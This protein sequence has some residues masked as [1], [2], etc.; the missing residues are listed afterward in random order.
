[1]QTAKSHIPKGNIQSGFDSVKQ[2]LINYNQQYTFDIPLIMSPETAAELRQLGLI[3]YKAINFMVNNYK[4]CLHIIPRTERELEILNI[5]EKFPY[6]IGTFRTDFIIDSINNIKI[7]EINAG[8]PFNGIFNSGIFREIAL[9]QA[10]RLNIAGIIDHY[11]GV[12]EYI[13]DYIGGAQQ[14]TV[15]YGEEAAGDRAV[16]SKLFAASGVP[17]NLIPIVE[18]PS[19]TNTMDDAFIIIELLGHEI[20]T[21][22]NEMIELLAAKGTH[23][24]ILTLLNSG[25]KKFFRALNHPEFLA[26][27]LTADEI[28][29][30]TKYVTPTYIYGADDTV[31][32]EAYENKNRF[33]LK[34]HFLGRSVEVYGGRL[35]EET[36]WRRL[37][38]NGSVRDMILQPFIE[39]RKFHGTIGAEQRN[40]YVTGT[41]LF[42]NDQFFGPGFYRTHIS[43]VS[44]HRGSFRKIAQL[45]A[46]RNQPRGDLQFI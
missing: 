22:S 15:F 30:M 27:A 10:E 32:N 29:I 34:H 26:A 20:L 42:F 23:N 16:Y 6:R 17:C 12:F 46:E 28:T 39:Q 38:D 4:N 19:H 9:R 13:E 35:T 21:L 7:I 14:I 36:V 24:S 8:H 5:C 31:W 18:L 25:S 43:P 40:D 11:A 44:S 41:L 2:E 33:I 3:M 45:V 1:M 37:F